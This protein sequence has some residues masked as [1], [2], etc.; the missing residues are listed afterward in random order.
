MACCK[1]GD[2]AIYVVNGGFQSEARP[3]ELFLSKHMTKSDDE[4][5]S[6]GKLNS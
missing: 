2:G 1:N 3:T 6:A 5:N 4:F